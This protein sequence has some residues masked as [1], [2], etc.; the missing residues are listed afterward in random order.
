MSNRRRRNTRTS[1]IVIETISNKNF[2]LI[3]CILLVIIIG[4]IIVSTMLHV[5]ET[6]KIAQEQKRISQHVEDIYTSVEA[7]LDELNNYKSNSIV[8]I[9]ALGDIL[10]GNNLS[11]YGV[12]ETGEYTDIF[13]DIS[14]Y[15]KDSDMVLGT[16]EHVITDSS[17]IFANAVKNSKVNFVTL[18]HNHAM[19]NGQ[20]GLN[21]TKE[22]LEKIGIETTGIYSEESKD[23]VKIKEIKG[24]KLAFLSY[25]YDNG[26]TG[27]NIY[28][29]DMAKK[30]LEYAKQNANFSVVLIHWGDVN[31]NM[32][33]NTQK[34][35]AKFLVENG[36]NLIIG[37]H[38]SAV[39]PMEIMQNNEGAD[40]LVAYSLGDYTS[41]FE[42]ENSNLELILNIQLFYD[43]EE[44]KVSLYKVDYIPIYMN[45]Y[46]A[47]Q[48]INRYKL[49]DMKNEIANYGVE[50]SNLDK[51]TYDKLVRGID[52]LNGI[53]KK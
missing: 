51:G 34:S 53:I 40:C 52:R 48:T 47:K 11:K 29:E 1:N 42:S 20:S 17:K 39:Q 49:L 43:V 9:S 35:Q 45:D 37:A 46:G 2:I 24:I 22:Y 33:N 7:D 31:K 30:D 16:Y 4:C 36:A 18:A 13:S 10:F 15:M 50:G 26:K 12:N 44:N 3:S 19:D 6:K 32:A 38:P 41:D 5:N 27:V 25:T 21:E 14:E 23:R 8:R 28:S